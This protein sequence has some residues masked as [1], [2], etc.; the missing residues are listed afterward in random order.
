ML[1]RPIHTIG[2]DEV[3]IWHL[4]AD[5][6]TDPA[7]VDRATTLLADDERQRM[8]VF[9]HE[10]DRR[11][12]LWS[13][14]LMRTVLASYAGCTPAD[15]RF[16]V[17][18]F[19]KPILQDVPLQFNVS[20]SRGA[21]ALAVSMRLVGIDIEERQRKV[22][23]LGLARRYFAEGEA[24]HLEELAESERG[25]AFFA[26]WTL[27]EAYV[28][29]IGRGLTFPLD[30]FCFDLDVDRLRHFRA[31]KDFVSDEWHFHQFDL[32]ERHCGA[33]AVEGERVRVDLRDWASAFVV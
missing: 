33:L 20:H 24:R 9:G 3:H 14:C 18:P 29:G 21:V 11:T 19:G 12:Y 7:I 5:R 15:L 32:G 2:A 23:H 31:L 10:S 4:L 13:R 25:P 22:E 8:N 30:A 17:N 6:L 1:H 27:K 28:K 16:Q 26:I